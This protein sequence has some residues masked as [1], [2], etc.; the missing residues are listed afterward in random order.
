MPSTIGVRR[1]TAMR[2]EED[3]M[4]G[5]MKLSPHSAPQKRKP[6]KSA[7]ISENEPNFTHAST[8]KSARKQRSIAA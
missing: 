8:E 4:P 7:R 1:P 5:M 2:M 3:V 6:P